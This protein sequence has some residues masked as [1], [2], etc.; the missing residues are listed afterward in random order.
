MKVNSSQIELFDTH[1]TILSLLL[2]FEYC[3]YLDPLQSSYL[4]SIVKK[5]KTW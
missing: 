2:S 5:N 3:K 1:L 4:K